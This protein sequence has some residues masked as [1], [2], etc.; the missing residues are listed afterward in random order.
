MVYDKFLKRKVTNQLNLNGQE[1]TFTHLQ[2]DK[3]HRAEP[4]PVTISIKGIFHQSAS[5]AQ[6][7]SS[8]GAVISSKPQPMILCLYSDGSLIKKNDTLKIDKQGYRVTNVD[9]VQQLKTA[10]QI[11]L[12]VIQNG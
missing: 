5:Y 2:E 6:K 12:E 8:D 11:S 1:F 9:D 7:N 4:T 3:Y 10:I